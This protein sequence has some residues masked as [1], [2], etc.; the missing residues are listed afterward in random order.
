MAFARIYAFTVFSSFP[1]IVGDILQRTTA[2]GNE[3]T[4][5]E[6][7]VKRIVHGESK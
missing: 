7:F 4:D 2:V 6:Q 1:I 5:G 3:I